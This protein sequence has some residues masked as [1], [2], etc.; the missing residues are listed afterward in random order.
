[1][2]G[3]LDRLRRSPVLADGA[4]GSYLFR[5]TGRL[6]EEEHVYEALSLDEP[7]LIREVHLAYLKAGAE[8]LTTNTFGANKP[9]LVDLGEY[10]SCR[11]INRAAVRIAR[12]AITRWVEVHGG[13]E[14]IYVFGSVGPTL[15]ENQTTDLGDVYGEQIEGLI[16]AGV[17]ALILETFASL[18]DLLELVRYVR[19]EWDEKIPI[20]AEM[21]LRRPEGAQ[22]WHVVPR[23]FV[24]EVSEAGAQVVGVNCCTPW[25]ALAFVDA[26]AQAG[27]DPGSPALISAMP[28]GGGFQRIGNRYMTRVNPE[29][30]GRLARTLVQRGVRLVGGCCEVHPEH[31]R[32]MANFLRSELAGRQLKAAEVRDLGRAAERWSPVGAEEKQ[33]NGPFSRKLFEGE[34]A[35]SVEVLPPRGTSEEVLVRKVSL[36]NEM[37]ASGLV[38]A[39]DLTDGSRGI[40]LAP[41]A[42]FVSVVRERLD[43]DHRSGDRLEFIPHFTCRDLNIMGM[44]SRLIGFHLLRIRNVLFITGDP[45]K[46]SPSYP[47]SSGVFEAQSTDVIRWAHECLNA[48][49]DFGGNVL[50]KSGDPRTRFT[51]GS[52]FEP[53]A[54]DLRRELDKLERKLAAGADYIMTQPVFRRE[55]L[56]ILDP[57]RQ[58]ARVLAGVMI[59]R[60]LAQAERIGEV[61][62]IVIPPQVFEVLSRYDAPD[63]QRKA[64]FDLA[65]DQVRWVRQ[66]GWAGLYLMS[67]AAHGAALE[68]LR[69]AFG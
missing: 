42:D 52:G 35:V 43:W 39:V 25:D 50:A 14:A 65:V 59:L 1:M 17:D 61:S 44:Q 3:L 53:E 30:M 6:S 68:V 31:I 9:S 20:V 33:G 67:P 45:P 32:E 41:A 54:L 7:D 12:D 23:E 28:N 69:A 37:A 11:E 48:G 40:A 18:R 56:K 4:M 8:C 57:Y 29:F 22:V 16:E 60:D 66:E 5:L 26:L 47:R 64:A 36:I 62:G 21:S 13:S 27:Y 38:D 51:I 34:F 24:R 63:D 49:V 19:R 58:R 15:R 46:M 10:R 2:E 55:V